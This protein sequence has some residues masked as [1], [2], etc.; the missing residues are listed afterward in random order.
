MRA[1]TRATEGEGEGEGEG[2]DPRIVKVVAIFLFGHRRF[3]W[4]ALGSLEEGG[5]VSDRL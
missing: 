4:V 2:K 1:M 3:T 5:W